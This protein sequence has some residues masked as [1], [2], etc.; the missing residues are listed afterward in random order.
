MRPGIEGVPGLTLIWGMIVRA[1]REAQKCKTT[2]KIRW[3]SQV[4]AAMALGAARM[5]ILRTKREKR[6]YRCPYCHSWHLTSEDERS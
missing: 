6:H 2:G 3:R 1:R 4:D 5:R